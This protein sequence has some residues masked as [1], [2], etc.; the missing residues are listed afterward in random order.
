[1]ARGSAQPADGRSWHFAPGM[2]PLVGR[3]LEL[4]QLTQHLAAAT[5]G[6]PQVVL[7][8]GDAGVGK[9]RLARELGR[10]A[11]SQGAT[12]VAGRCREEVALPYLPFRTSFFQLIASLEEQG[13]SQAASERHDDLV[14]RLVS[15]APSSSSELGSGDESEQYRLF[16]AVAQATAAFV[17]DTP[18]VLIIE[19]AHW[20]DRSSLDLLRYLVI[21]MADRALRRRLRL[22]I[23]ATC[24]PEMN[25]SVSGALRQLRREE[26]CSELDI[27]GLDAPESLELVRG[28]GY[29]TSDRR[30]AAAL[31][32]T[33]RGNPLFIEA[34]VRDLRRREASGEPL[35]PIEPKSPDDLDTTITAEIKAMSATTRHVLARIG[36]LGDYVT[37]EDV[38]G[39]I[40]E[41]EAVISR[42][43]E[44]AEAAG[45]I[46]RH[47][48]TL[49][50]SHPMFW[51][52]VR[53]E[54]SGTDRRRAYLEI[55]D[56]LGRTA[57]GPD[58]DLELAHYLIEAGPD[59]NPERVLAAALRGGEQ[60]AAM[61]AWAEAGR[62][63]EAAAA[64]AERLDRSAADIA[65]WQLL[66]GTA[67]LRD[68]D[69]ERSRSHLAEAIDG[70]RRVGDIRSLAVA[71]S[72]DVYL[73]LTFGGYGTV[74]DL[75]ELGEL[76][77]QLETTEPAQAARALARM[78]SAAY[79]RDDFDYASQLAVRALA[80]ADQ[81]V[82]DEA[83]ISSHCS[84]GIVAWS[85]LDL[86]GARFH[87]EDALRRAR[88]VESAWFEEAAG[89]RL[90]LTL[91]WL[92]HLE[93]ANEL[94][95]QV[96]ESARRTGNWPACTLALA[97]CL[98]VAVAR[99]EHHQAEQL[100]E[101]A[102]LAM[103][104]SDYS[105]TAAF[106]FPVLAMSRLARAEFDGAAE[107][108]HRWR[109]LETGD[110]RVHA[111]FLVS[112]V[113]AF[114]SACSDPTLEPPAW[115]PRSAVQM[116]LRVGA[117]AG[118]AALGHLSGDHV[119]MASDQLV[120]A[121]ARID[122]AGMMLTDGL[123][124]LVPRVLGVATGALGRHDEACGHLR[125]A[126][127]VAHQIGAAPEAG[128]AR[129]DLARE[130]A[131]VGDETAL[132]TA[133]QAATELSAVGM[134]KVA[135][136]AETL[137][138][139]LQ[140]EHSSQGDG[141]LSGTSLIVFTDVV[142]STGLT[143]RLGDVAYRE[144]ADRLLQALRVQA[145]A[146]GGEVMHGVTLGDGILALFGSGRGAITF[147]E[148]AHRSATQFVVQLRV[149]IHVG[150]VIRSA[151]M[152]SGGAVNIAA[153]VCSA[154]PP[155]ETL[156]SEPVRSVA[157]TSTSV[158]FEDRGEFTLRGVREP[159]RLF[160]ARAR[161][162][163]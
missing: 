107:L 112:V 143:E 8:S 163:G 81:V 54:I 89:S 85:C 56:A 153:R 124:L 102:W 127:E 159:H 4:D 74:V 125:R 130:L 45:V 152:V 118:P 92:G 16:A 103:R 151:D 122:N 161:Q 49:Q 61:C 65:Q 23:L 142:D 126:I 33:S 47:D 62:C 77:Q 32:E 73:E 138:D 5:E 149:G 35:T 37:I 1:M 86:S 98:G 111:L 147:A 96:S 104:F 148:E 155:G 116:P 135:R 115:L 117:V 150:D 141:V 119:A 63:F 136:D 2:A 68:H 156:V 60:A 22:F 36:L 44:E 113:E 109:S 76:A 3:V 7:L 157:R 58:R 21:D 75:K 160:A 51:H 134:H 82:D 139:R 15:G 43:L 162:P 108:L 137:R 39:I 59:A 12:V 18:L 94:G 79:A 30:V 53:S 42:A 154:A 13:A 158:D 121:L 69:A 31:H 84:L 110:K 78:S 133:R 128:R 100:G 64:A 101:E 26:I 34:L 87:F 19:D 88:K 10:R 80:I 91:L 57:H 144:V 41:G 93:E 28:L 120:D 6:R 90:A 9:S 25:P 105:W 52:L 71:L 72:E 48:T 129:L 20:A 17:L 99:G 67:Y 140:R 131:R 27:H 50:F 14:Q 97:A 70:F 46:T 123:Q 145:E 24:R 95:S 55:A 29:Q 83:A 146:R 40:M 106:V 38:R 11:G 114:V 132:A 66:A